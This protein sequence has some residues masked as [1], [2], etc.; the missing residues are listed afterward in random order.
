VLVTEWPEFSELDWDAAGAAMRR[1]VVIDGRNV[2]PGERLAAAG[3]AYASFG[4]GTLLPDAEPTG[5][6]SGELAWSNS[7][8][9]GEG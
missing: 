3:F 8:S 5:A 4:R 7:L 9:L 2:L 6:R 1:R